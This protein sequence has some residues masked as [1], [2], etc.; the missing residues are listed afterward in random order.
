MGRELKKAESGVMRV[1]ERVGREDMMGGRGG[2]S[3]SEELEGG[4][5]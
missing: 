2:V 1:G 5:V 3:L 4:G